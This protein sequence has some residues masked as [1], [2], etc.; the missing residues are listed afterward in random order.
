MSEPFS[1]KERPTDAAFFIVLAATLATMLVGFGF[2]FAVLVIGLLVVVPAVE[3]LR[4]DGKNELWDETLRDEYV[5]DWNGWGL[6]S[7]RPDRLV[8]GETGVER[9]DA[10]RTERTVRTGSKREELARL[11]ERYGADELTD[12]EFEHEL[13][14]LVEAEPDRGAARRSERLRVTEYKR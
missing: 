9:A 1:P 12:A 8:R 11:R 10:A 7:E 6:P 4:G 14:R 2:S 5:G 13:E 3:L